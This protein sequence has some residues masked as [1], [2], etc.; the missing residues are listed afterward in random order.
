MKREVYVWIA[1]FLVV[2]AVASYFRFFYQPAMELSVHIAPD[3]RQ[4]YPYQS[5][6]VPITVVNTGSALISNMPFGLYLNKNI[7]TVYKATIPVG[8]QVLVYFNFTPGTAGTYNITFVA[9]PNRLYNVL[10]RSSAQNS[11]D[12]MVRS[13]AKAEPFVYFPQNG[14]IGE[15]RFNMTPE[16][17]GISQLLHYNYSV[18]ILALTDSGQVNG[19]FYP[20]FEVYNN[21]IRDIAISHAYYDNYSLADVWI[22]GYLNSNAIEEAALGQGLNVSAYNSSVYMI[23]F[24]NRTTLCSFYSGG[25]LQNLVSVGGRQCTSF[26]KYRNTFNYT[27]NFGLLKTANGSMLNYTGYQG[28]IK[29]SGAIS[30]GSNSI[31]FESIV[32]GGNFTNKC[33]GNILD[34]SNVSYCSTTYLLGSN[35]VLSEND[36]IVGNYSIDVWSISNLSSMQEGEDKALSIGGAYNL[37]GARIK[38]VSAFAKANSTCRLGTGV[39]CSNPA[40]INGNLTFTMT[41]DLNSTISL[42][43]GSCYASGTAPNTNINATVAPGASTNVTLRCYKNG[44]RLTGISLYILA[45]VDLFYTHAGKAGTFK[46]YAYIA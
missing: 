42:N 28:A 29:Y 31:L 1:F 17:Y 5:V 16:G 35:D 10:N 9:D 34:I 41:N 30:F 13:A 8:K 39:A 6:R 40:I 11:T 20:T 36:R 38:Y 19:F 18:G 26:L 15:D 43:Y 7:S 37:S 12:I 32:N 2:I 14:I 3:G 33:Y 46:G 45:Y 22:G 21:Y 23:N 24:G 4:F 25:W 44:K 27:G